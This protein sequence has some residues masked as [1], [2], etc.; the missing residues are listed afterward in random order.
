MI[1]A[2]GHWVEHTE[3]SRPLLQEPDAD[4][5]SDGDFMARWLEGAGFA[6]DSKDD[7]AVAALVGDETEFAGWVDVEV[8]RRLDGGGFVLDER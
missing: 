6:V 8:A 2:T 7:Y 3:V 1:S 5:S 4:W